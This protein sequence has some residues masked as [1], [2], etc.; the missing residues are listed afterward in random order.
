MSLL[1]NI[2]AALK[3]AGF[4]H[5]PIQDGSLFQFLD[6]YDVPALSFELS[7]SEYQTS[8]VTEFEVH[9]DYLGNG[10]GYIGLKHIAMSMIEQG[11]E[12]IDFMEVER[13]GL[14]FWPKYGARPTSLDEFPLVL[15]AIM[16]DGLDETDD[17]DLREIF[18]LAHDDPYSAWGMLSAQNTESSRSVLSRVSERLAGGETMH[19][20]LN[21]T[22]V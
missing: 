19:M 17:A 4:E 9:Q 11:V 20:D 7:V 10:F 14:T 13:D 22:E 1:E 8:A 16:D 18:A 6:E 12:E 3:D 5:D 2:S 21:H 15:H